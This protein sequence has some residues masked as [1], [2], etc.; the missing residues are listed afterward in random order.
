MFTRFSNTDEI[1]HDLDRL[2]SGQA[3]GSQ[4]APL[5][6]RRARGSVV[7]AGVSDAEKGPSTK[8]PRVLV[9]GMQIKIFFMRERK[10][11]PY[12]N[13]VRFREN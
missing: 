11:N 7:C 9:C 10:K 6:V 13:W 1:S 2:G 12:L 4:F 3:H 8:C 5:V